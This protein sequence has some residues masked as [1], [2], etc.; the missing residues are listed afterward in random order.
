MGRSA[1]ERFSPSESERLD[2]ISVRLLGHPEVRRGEETLT[3]FRSNR[4][5][6][7]LGFLSFHRGWRS[8]EQVAETLWPQR[9]PESSR[10]NLRQTILYTRQLLGSSGI[11]VNGSSISLNPEVEV[12][13]DYILRVQSRSATDLQRVEIALKALEVRR[14][15][16]LESID[17]EW[18]LGPRAQLD[19]MYIVA[20]TTLADDAM[21]D[22]P[23]RALEYLERVIAE[24][25]LLD[26]ARARKIKALRLTGENAAARREFQSYQQLLH[27]ELGISPSPLVEDALESNLEKSEKR[28]DEARPAEPDIFAIIAEMA[29]GTRPHQAID[30]ACSMTPYWVKKGAGRRG[31]LSLE[32]AIEQAGAGLGEERKERVEL[33]LVELSLSEEDIKGASKRLD[34]VLATSVSPLTETRALMLAVRVATTSFNPTQAQPL[35]SRAREIA[36]RNH[37][38]EEETEIHRLQSKLLLILDDPVAAEQSAFEAVAAV[39]R[40][41]DRLALADALLSL[42]YAQH[43]AAHLEAARKTS[44]LVMDSVGETES[45]AATAIRTNLTRL[46]E[47]MGEHEGIE[48]GYARGVRECSRYD[49][50]FRLAVNLTYLGD[51]LTTRGRYREAI[52]VHSRALKL[53]QTLSEQLGIATSLRGLGR[54]RL[55]LADF[56]GAR[57]ALA[58]SARLFLAVEALPGHASSLLEL[59][60]TESKA[61]NTTLA[62]RLASRSAHLLRA[63]TPSGQWANG[64][65]G[66]D[67]LGQAERLE[68]RL[69]KDERLA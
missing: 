17:D 51:Y 68:M 49:G 22:S 28:P 35:L 50:A 57:E 58:E 2:Q 26:G 31:R 59:A 43:R 54:A 60:E 8:R 14:G 44:L 47:E 13:V 24:E 12:D 48:E 67:L 20:L 62:L 10:Q 52:D 19:H 15:A 41:Q 29:S 56:E 23:T 39:E 66:G 6:A 27:E 37:F 36:I 64:P 9:G 45:P 42:A 25:P 5:L 63:L 7:L 65:T 33:C 4:I 61:G 11:L 34:Q 3:V 21:P 53:R 46:R 40:F 55:G 69:K 16:F 1:M 32:A 30:L 18:L 38:Q